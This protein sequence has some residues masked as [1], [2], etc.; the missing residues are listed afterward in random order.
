MLRF[1]CPYSPDGVNNSIYILAVA[2]LKLGHEPI[3]IGGFTTDASRK[4]RLYEAFDVEKVPEVQVLAKSSNR[5]VLWMAWFKKSTKLIRDLE[6][7]IV[8]SNGVIPVPEVG[9]R[10][11]R[12]HDVPKFLHQKLVTRWLLR[13]YHYY[14]FSSS[15]IEN[16]FLTNFRVAKDKCL[17]IPLPINLALYRV[18]P[19]NEREHAILFV[20][21]RERRNLRFALEVFKQVCQYDGDIVMYLVGTREIP[22]GDWPRDR[23]IPLGF[24]GRKELRELYSRVKLLLI[25]SSYEGF[26]YPV[27]EAFASGTPVVGSDAIPSELLIDNFNGFRIHGFKAKVY[28]DAVLKLLRDEVLWTEMSRNA[29]ETARRHDA[30]AIA[31][32]YLE[33]YEKNQCH[34]KR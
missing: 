24:V 27:L 9:F 20:D 33:L 15:I 14:V 25:P 17:I 31:R 23:V 26:G 11:L 4:E 2:F 30:T 21:G 1:G 5:L 22:S 3:V 10:I 12:I 18:R 8:I 16:E 29:L 32:K 7:D 28:V 6:P 13:K 19:L 34:A